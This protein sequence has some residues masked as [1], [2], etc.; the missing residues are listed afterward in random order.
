[1][2]D[3]VS[4]IKSRIDIV[5]FIGSYVKLKRS[6][7]NHLGLCPFHREKSPSFNV[8]PN[9]QAYHCFGCQASGDIFSFV[10]AYESMNFREALEKLAP[11]AGVELQNNKRK[12]ATFQKEKQWKR[13]LNLAGHFFRETFLSHE[14]K[15]ARSILADRGFSTA[16][17]DSF[18]IGFAPD[19]WSR[20]CDR[21]LAK[22]FSKEDL[23]TMGLARKNEKGGI[24][25]FFRNRIM[26]PVRNVQGQ[27]IAFGGRVIDDAVPKYMNT[28]ETPLFNKSRTLF[29][30]NEA[31]TQLAEHGFFL[32]MEGYTDVMMVRQHNLGPA[33]ATL[34]TAMTEEHLRL[35]SRHNVPLFLVYDGDRAGQKAMEK[36]LPFALKLGVDTRAITLPQGQDPA[37]FFNHAEKN[38]SLWEQL[39]ANSVDLFEYKLKALITERGLEQTE[40]KVSIAKEMLKEL[41]LNRDEVRE[42]LYLDVMARDLNIQRNDLLRQLNNEKDSDRVVDLKPK[43]VVTSFR[44]DPAYFLLCLAMVDAGYRTRLEELTNMPQGDQVTVMVLKKW[45]DAHVHEGDIAH[46]HFEASLSPLE[47]EVFSQA[48]IEELPEQ[49][50]LPAFFDEKLKQWQGSKMKLIEI[51]EKIAKAEA[52]GDQA[53][54]VALLKA[55]SEALRNKG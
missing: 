34:G 25:D 1:M 37:D 43:L 3:E 10:M 6:G 50:A 14:G 24:Y 41:H 28:P 20:L 32:M 36:A 5:D 54:L 23:V 38:D 39:K 13:L 48:R 55:K 11:I 46:V 53:T 31:R 49:R 19:A 12:N 22:G 9:R 47:K 40:S 27:V 52:E 15:V 16:T 42:S 29:N 30:F 26:F 44:K 45:L 33:I 18:K 17:L 35:L 8:S 7:A 4:Q 21:A 2:G 51:N